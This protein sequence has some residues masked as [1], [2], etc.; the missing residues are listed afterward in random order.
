MIFHDPV[1][2]DVEKK[3]ARLCLSVQASKADFRGKPGKPASP[4]FA[5]FCAPKY[6]LNT[7]RIATRDHKAKRSHFEPWKCAAQHLTLQALK[8]KRSADLGLRTSF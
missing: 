3:D 2:M 5:L 4:G 1:Q 7:G 8:R 6:G